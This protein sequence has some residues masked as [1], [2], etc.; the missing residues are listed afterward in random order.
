MTSAPVR[1]ATSAFLG[2][3]AG[4]IENPDGEIPKTSNAIAIVLAVNWPP[5]APAPGEATDSSSAS[6][7]SVI[8]PAA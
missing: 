2:S 5:H 1:P 6:S 8:R 7:S 3:S 4:T